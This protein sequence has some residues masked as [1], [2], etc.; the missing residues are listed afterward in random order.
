[1]IILINYYHN[2]KVVNITFT[3]LIK[4]YICCVEEYFFFFLSLMHKIYSNT[5]RKSMLRASTVARDKI[6]SNCVP[7][8]LLLLC[9]AV[10]ASVVSL[11]ASVTPVTASV[12]SIVGPV[13]V[14]VGGVF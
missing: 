3:I 2:L 13:V 10:V 11:T 14:T 4:T 6:E 5:P 8:P 7:L 12:I 1:M 9:A